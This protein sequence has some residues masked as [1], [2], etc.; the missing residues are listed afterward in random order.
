MENLNIAGT[1]LEKERKRKKWR[2]KQWHEEQAL[3]EYLI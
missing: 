2:L 3:L 1:K